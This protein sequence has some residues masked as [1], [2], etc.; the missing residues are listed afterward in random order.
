MTSTEATGYVNSTL[1]FKCKGTNLVFPAKALELRHEYGRARFRISPVGGS[2]EQW[3]DE[4]SLVFV[5]NPT[6]KKGGK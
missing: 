3:V 2:G 4:K 5:P 6:P 1:M